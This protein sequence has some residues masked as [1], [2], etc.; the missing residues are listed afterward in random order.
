M[1]PKGAPVDLEYDGPDDKGWHA[2]HH[3][4]TLARPDLVQRLIDRKADLHAT[5]HHDSTALHVLACVG[6]QKHTFDAVEAVAELLIG[7]N[8]PL[9]ARDNRGNTALLRA[10]QHGTLG[11]VLPLL[12]SAEASGV[13]LSVA[14][15]DDGQSALDRARAGGHTEVV[16]A[17]EGG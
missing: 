12:R 2:V 14:L 13:S 8:A 3:A 5:T 11:V 9:D 17:I 16:D 6:P 15:N 1:E 7:A 10:A 4:A